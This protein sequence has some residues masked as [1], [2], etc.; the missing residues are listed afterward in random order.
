MLID[1]SI[2]ITAPHDCTVASICNTCSNYYLDWMVYRCK[3]D[4]DISSFPGAWGNDDLV[5]CEY[6][7]PSNYKLQVACGG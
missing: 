1:E 5:G 3:Y 4:L 6:Y 7:E 2:I